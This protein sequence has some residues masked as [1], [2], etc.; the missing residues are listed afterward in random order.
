MS[1]ENEAWPAQVRILMV[2]EAL[3]RGGAER[4]MLALTHGMLNRSYAVEVLE[5]IGV[6]PGQAHFIDEFRDLGIEPQLA[7]DVLCSGRGC[8]RRDCHKW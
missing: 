3:A 7:S 8:L 1:A 2:T 5:L 4:Q 6:V